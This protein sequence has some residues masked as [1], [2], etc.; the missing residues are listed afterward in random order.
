[1][2]TISKTMKITSIISE[3]SSINNVEFSKRTHNSVIARQEMN[4][5]IAI[6]IKA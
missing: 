3:A 1:M 2:K 4:S 5:P 6:E